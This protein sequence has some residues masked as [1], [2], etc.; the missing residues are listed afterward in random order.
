MERL[1]G[2][3]VESLRETFAVAVVGP[4][5]CRELLP[6][7]V[8]VAE[9]PSG[10]LSAFLMHA[11]ARS[12]GLVH[13][14]RPKII[15]AGSGLT[16][17]IAL[18][19]ARLCGAR[20]AVYLHGLDVEAQHWAY[21]TFW[22]NSF[23]RFDLVIVNSRFTKGLALSAKVPEDRIRILNPGVAL[24][25]MQD[26]DERR[27]R[28]R[29]RHGLGNAPLMLYVGRITP[30][31]GLS[32][33]ARDILPEVLAAIPDARLV[34]LGD[35]PRGALLSSSRGELD[36]TRQILNE[37]QLASSVMFLGE[38][39]QDDPAL[40]DAYFAA[41]VHVFPVQDRPGDNE[42]F[43]MVAIEAAAHDLPS[44]AFSVGGVADAVA[45]SR[46]GTLIP[47]GDTRAFA[48]AII[49]NLTRGPKPL[50]PRN[51]AEEFAWPIFAGKL[52]DLLGELIAPARQPDKLQ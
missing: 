1:I 48:T 43:G 46:S 27:R 51:F 4:R 9:V 21:R 38:L 13:S 25:D 20:S 52:N 11:A 19:A 24:P 50:D 31:K 34:V 17:P 5:G 32:V 12:L 16:A 37:C 15:L 44:V 47:S 33:F 39:G 18:F 28:F 8:A 35:E 6:G 36:A 22:R 26:R 14:L 42:G 40:S 7:D 23:R 29:E 45:D 2:R 10:P 30:R 41:D 49:F 3:V